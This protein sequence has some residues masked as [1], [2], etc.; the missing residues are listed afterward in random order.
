MLDLSKKGFACGGCL[1]QTSPSPI[2]I[3]CC[4]SVSSA[5]II[6]AWSLPGTSLLTAGRHLPWLSSRRFWTGA[7]A[8]LSPSARQLPANWQ[9]KML[10]QATKGT[11]QGLLERSGQPG[12]SGR[13]GPPGGADGIAG[14]GGIPFPDSTIPRSLTRP[15]GM[16]SRSLRLKMCPQGPAAPALPWSSLEM[17]NPRP[18]PKPQGSKSKFK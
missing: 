2:L 4:Y 9:V 3:V 6:H 18:N 14:G 7:P 5:S 13:F 8:K 11:L 17:Q 1:L 10:G 15:I 12:L 16:F